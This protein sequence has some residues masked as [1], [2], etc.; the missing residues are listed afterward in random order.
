MAIATGSTPCGRHQINQIIANG[1]CFENAVDQDVLVVE[2][3]RIAFSIG[4]PSQRHSRLL[5]P[6]QYP[7]PNAGAG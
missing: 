2:F 1:R 5:R 6:R 4:A 7:I 3:K